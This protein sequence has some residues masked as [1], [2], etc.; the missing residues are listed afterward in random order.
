MRSFIDEVVSSL[1]ERYGDDVSSLNLVLP[2]H[3]ATLFFSDALSRIALRPI[4]Q[5]HFL[6]VNDLMQQ[7]SGI[8]CGDRIKLV[9]ELYKTYHRYHD[10]TF[11][12]FFFWGDVLLSDF[13]QIDKYRIDADLLFSNMIDLHALESLSYLTTEQIAVISRFWQSFGEERDFS[14]E[15]TRFMSIWRTLGTI[16]REYRTTLSAQGLAYEGMM[17]RMAAERIEAGDLPNGFPASQSHYVIVGFNALSACEKRLF[18]WLRDS[19]QAE[20][21]WDYDDYY[22]GN[23]NH[24]AG[25]FLRSNIREYPSSRD[26]GSH[27]HFV[28][29]KELTVVSAPSDSLQC[30]YVHTFLKELLQRGLKPDKE[31]AIVLTDESLLLPVLYSIPDEISAVN[32]TMGYPLRQTM[33]Y[34]FVER[35]LELQ[36]RK[37]YKK[38]G[39]LQFYHSDVVG[40]LNHPCILEQMSTRSRELIA[41]I[42]HN[43]WIYVEARHIVVTGVTDQI[44]SAVDGWEELADYLRQVLSQVGSIS[45]AGE[46][47]L[48]REFFSVI[49][50]NLCQVSTSLRD[51]ALENVTVSVFSSLLRKILQGIRIPYEGEP[52]SGIQ[53]MGILE[54]RNLDFEHVLI[55]SANDDT[56]P[57]SPGAGSSF[58]PYNLRL[59]YGLPTPMHH[60][61][62]YAYYFYR[63]LQ[64]ASVVHVAYCSHSDDK[65]T[66]EPS[67]YIYQLDYESP[68]EVV[69][70]QIPLS[71]SLA[72]QQQLTIP[73]T[74][75]VEERLRAFLDGGGRSF[76]PTSFH[77][78]IECPLKFYFRS[79]ERFHPEDEVTE[80][81]DL[82][83]FGTILHKAMELLYSP[84]LH[85]AKPRGEIRALINSSA[86]TDAVTQAINSEFL[87]NPT[88]NSDEYEGS[89]LLVHDVVVQYINRCI[90]P[91]DGKEDPDD[92][93]LHPDFQIEGLERRITAPVSFTL[94]DET[95]TVTFA[96]TSDRIDRLADGR[97]RVVDYKTGKQKNGF[98]SL[99]ALFSTD[100]NQRNPAV[101]QTLLYSMM[102]NRDTGSDVL[103]TLYYVRYLNDPDYSPLLIEGEKSNKREVLSFAPYLEPLQ[104]YLQT[105]LASLFDFSEPFRQCEEPKTCKHCDFREI[106]R[107]K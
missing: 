65:H 50:D 61:G 23:T 45:S 63:L 10:E 74:G 79:I 105:T 69:H 88:L 59:A 57:G 62:V 93:K 42:Q 85:V 38:D 84:L 13:D 58:V 3:R 82:P 75:E 15:K 51:S 76:S 52:L 16:Y 60:E 86:V 26:V 87:H 35:L 98:K 102:V 4:W 78:Y 104:A 70:T 17:H 103:P 90:L 24:E 41:D 95:H 71:V 43:Q 5:P 1:Y 97:I 14:D 19:G 34:S 68:H 99:D 25:L 28:Q 100:S 77:A 54:T 39:T 32:V 18:A 106:C 67:R 72:P 49:I 46:G 40:I 8:S 66:G 33:A 29:A 48:R 2:S 9:T 91:Y 92:S 81:I 20:F 6:S 22:V 96:G 11:D 30:K 36:R 44:F 37:R 47:P 56:F 53:V 7:I 107:R 27:D 73:K 64:R 21:W 80:E 12:E 31:T 94:G 101:L 89:V 55:L 83:M